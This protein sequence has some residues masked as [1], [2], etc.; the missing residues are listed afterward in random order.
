M[1][2][3]SAYVLMSDLFRFTYFFS[4]QKDAPWQKYQVQ[5]TIGKTKG[6]LFLDCVF[7]VLS[8]SCQFFHAFFS[9]ISKFFKKHFNFSKIFQIFIEIFHIFQEIFQFFLRI[10]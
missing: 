8:D 9:N 6:Y 2:C 3:S 10:I 5:K 1:F 7:M 4:N